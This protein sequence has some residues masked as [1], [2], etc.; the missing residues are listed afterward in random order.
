MIDRIFRPILQPGQS[1]QG[2][3]LLVAKVLSALIVLGS[4]VFFLIALPARLDW[5]G[6][7]ALDARAVFTRATDLDQAVIDRYTALFPGVALTIEISV[8]LLYYLIATLIFSRRSEEWLGLITAAG[9]AAFALHITPTLHT[10][11]G[12]DPSR[13]FIGSLAKGIGLGLAFLFLYLFPGGYYSPSWFRLFFLGWIVWVALWLANPGSLFSFR[14]PYTI[15]VRG[16]VL[17]MTWWGIGV[18]SQLYRYAYISGP[19]ERQQTKYITFGVAIVA[20]SYVLYVPLREAMASLPQP[21]LAQTVFQMVAPYVFLAMVALIPITIAFSILRY[22]LW[23]IDLIIRR[24]LIYSVLSA[25]L[26]VIYLLI[27][28]SLQALVSDW[29]TGLPNIVLAGST[30]VVVVLV[31]PLRRRIQNMIDRRFYRR[32]YDA[33]KAL[34]RFAALARDDADMQR[35]TLSI[36]NVIQEVLQP[37][38]VSV[39]LPVDEHVQISQPVQPIQHSEL[40]STRRYD[41]GQ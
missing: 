28:I 3:Q 21:E 17:L 24:T 12:D 1:L 26:A 8:M 39:W 33:E 32:K 14:D 25:T 23:D 2:N 9:L 35:L 38:R 7:L 19:V 27:V 18:F 16:F 36:V 15:S 34:A 5:L 40:S 30:L 37:E 13:I 10:W 29:M 6:N 4:L 31:N 20:I 22:R 11:M 41:E